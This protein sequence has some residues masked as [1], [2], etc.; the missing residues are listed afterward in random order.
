MN[1]APAKPPGTISLSQYGGSEI[2]I[3]GLSTDENSAFQASM[4]GSLWVRVLDGNLLT[5]PAYEKL[6]EVG[7]D[8]LMAPFW[9][10]RE[11]GLEFQDTFDCVEYSDNRDHSSRSFYITA[12]GAGGDEDAYRRNA[13]L[14]TSYGFEAMRSQRGESGRF[15]EHWFLCSLHC[16]KGAL[17]EFF[18]RDDIKKLN[19]AEKADKAINWLCRRVQFGSIDASVQRACLTTD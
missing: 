11:P 17:H 5:A 4:E 12:V 6:P 18:R 9:K 16:S 8:P 10:Q 7:P 1:S 15:W 2:H 3:K 19:E 14:L 13:A